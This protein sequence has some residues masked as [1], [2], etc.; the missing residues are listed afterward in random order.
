MKLSEFKWLNPP[1][2]FLPES[3]RLTLSTDPETDFWQRTYYGFQNDNGH[4]YLYEIG[5]DFTF[6]LK[7]ESEAAAQYDQCGLIL[8]QDSEN[9]M[10]ASVEYENRDY[11]RLGSVVTNLGYS[12]WATTDI[13]AAIGT[14]WYRLSR[15][16]QDFYLEFSYDGS[17]Y[18]QMRM[19]HM[20]QQ[21][22]AARIGIYAC[23]PLKSSF[24]AVF[25]DF[26][27]KECNWEK[28]K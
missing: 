7:T 18:Q 15:R 25:S 1:R 24:R 8:Y 19:F 16:D 10:K 5:E 3:N 22:A 4:A 21:I 28:Y 26:E 27:L 9:W 17:R 14:V 12:D 6:S 2:I 11:A 13:P 23:S 20:Q